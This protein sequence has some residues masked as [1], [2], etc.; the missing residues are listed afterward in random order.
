M[1]DLIVTIFILWPLITILYYWNVAVKLRIAERKAGLVKKN[2]PWTEPIKYPSAKHG[3][4]KPRAVVFVEK[5]VEEILE[6][7]KPAGK[8]VYDPKQ[9]KV[10]WVPAE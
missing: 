2:N 10:V 1:I 4:P 8:H 7:A 3:I 5:E 9:H 6:D